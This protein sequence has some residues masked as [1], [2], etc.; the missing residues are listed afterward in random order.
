ME[1][2]IAEVERKI[3]AIEFLLSG[4]RVGNPE[5]PYIAVYARY[6]EGKLIEQN[7]KLQTEKHDLQTEKN[8]LIQKEIAQ[9][10]AGRPRI[11]SMDVDTLSYFN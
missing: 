5:N 10:Q 9:A 11:L 6:P 1:A 4:G 8:L 2:K 7:D 3:A